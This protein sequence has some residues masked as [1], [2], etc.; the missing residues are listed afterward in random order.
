MKF[1]DA[2]VHFSDPQYSECTDELAIEAKTAN[3]A[4]LVSNSMDFET[5]LGSLKLAERYPSF[6]YAALGI[7]PWSVSVLKKD[8]LQQTSELIYANSRNKALVAIGEI[9]LD[10]KYVKMTDEQLKV[11]SEMLRLAEKTELPAIVHSYST[12]EQV[13][14]ILPSYRL[15]KVLLHWYSHPLSALSKVV[16]KGYSITEGPPVV[17]SKRLQ[18]VVER[19]PV[20]NLLTETDGPVIYKKAPFDGK[21]TTPAFLPMVVKTIAEIKKMGVAEVAEQIAKNFEVFFNV[22]LN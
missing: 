12:T 21:R 18:K 7:H 11:F 2:H 1:V 3:V 22:K 9:G 20:T 17:Y 10:R 8:E 14:E 4:A 15:K 16:E 6:V 5:S 19:V 13:V